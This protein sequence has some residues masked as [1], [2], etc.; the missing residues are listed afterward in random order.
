MEIRF[1][2]QVA[3]LTGAGRGL[4]RAHAIA[5][6]SKGAKVVV[7]DFELNLGSK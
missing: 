4:G 6:A 1:D 3:I 2:Q 7:N 5:M